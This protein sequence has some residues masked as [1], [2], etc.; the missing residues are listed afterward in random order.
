MI[1]SAVNK[2]RSREPSQFV[3]P[4]RMSFAFA[5]ELHQELLELRGQD[6]ELDGSQVIQASGSCLEVLLAA[7]SNGRSTISGLR[8]GPPLRSCRKP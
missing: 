1:M 5:T 4:E 6:L 7:V 8:Y 3:L 2:E